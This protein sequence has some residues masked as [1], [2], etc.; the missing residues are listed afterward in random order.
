M[1]EFGTCLRCHTHPAQDATGLC[2]I[3][4]YVAK[5]DSPLVSTRQVGFAIKAL[6]DAAGMIRW[7]YGQLD[8]LTGPIKMGQVVYIV[9]GTGIGKT[10]LALDLVRRWVTAD[11][12]AG[13]SGR[14]PVGV[15]VLPL[16]TSAEEW[17]TS[18]AANMIGMNHGD[19]LELSAS[20]NDG[21]ASVNEALD[22]IGEAI[23]VQVTDPIMLKHFHLIEDETVSVSTL[24]RAFAVAKSMGHQVVLIDH[25]DQIGPND[26][27]GHKTPT[28]IQAI[29]H[30]NN[31]VLR[32]ARHYQMVAVC[33]SQA[34]KSYMGD[35]T[36][37]LLRFR[38]LELHHVMYAGYKTKNAAQIIGI[39]RPLM[40]GISRYDFA[41]ARE[42]AIDP[43]DALEPNR[44]GLNMMKL[45][46]RGRN[47]GRETRLAYVN[48][49]I[50][51]LTT[52]EKAHDATMR[53]TGESISHNTP[54][55]RKALNKTGS[56][57]NME[58]KDPTKTPDKPPTRRRDLDE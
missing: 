7:P 23:K 37:S 13:P 34:N 6:R 53:L 30:I 12:P 29:E 20:W 27:A 17:R 38:K 42:G 1:S 24:G 45:R 18:L 28:G 49:R 10:T 16:E 5:Y 21:D 43:V 51:D 48:G 31:E 52:D 44:I 15:T 35:G 40:G 33:M 11:M 56:A 46:F 4:A 36:N 3:C 47:E 19:V 57:S 32:L 41:L 39:F 22:R 50:R 14:A 26:E 8:S 54:Y 55:T 58:A 9:A 2:R 25:I